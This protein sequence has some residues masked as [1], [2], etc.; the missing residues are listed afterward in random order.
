ML[1]FFDVVNIKEFFDINKKLIK[2]TQNNSGIMISVVRYQYLEFYTR[3]VQRRHFLPGY[4]LFD[5]FFLSSC[6]DFAVRQHSFKYF[7]NY[8]TYCLN[9]ILVENL[10]FI[11]NF[12]FLQYSQTLGQ[13]TL[14]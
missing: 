3:H 2:Q 11:S 13:Q 14:I 8:L 9:T 12:L 5:K 6:K 1:F 4:M 7:F 10:L